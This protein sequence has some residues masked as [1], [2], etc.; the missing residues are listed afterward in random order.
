MM[1]CYITFEH[2][3][4]SPRKYVISFADGVKAVHQFLDSDDL[5]VSTNWEPAS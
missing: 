3:F 1:T 4:E 5:P 2:H